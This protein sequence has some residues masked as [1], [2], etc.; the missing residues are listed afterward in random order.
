MNLPRFSW[1][2]LVGMG[3]LCA[4]CSWDWDYYADH[5]ADNSRTCATGVSDAR[6]ARLS[7]GIDL[8]GWLESPTSFTNFI[9]DAALQ[10]FAQAGVTFVRA[11]FYAP[12]LFDTTQPDNLNSTNLS[13]FR[14]AVDRARAAGLGIVFVPYFEPTFKQQLEDQDPSTGAN[15]LDVLLRMWS[16]FASFINEQ[17][18]DWVYPELFG[19]ADFSNSSAWNRILQSLAKTVRNVAPRHT[20]I[21]D[22]NSGKFRVDWN[23]IGALKNLETIADDHNVIYGFI[24]FDPV[25][26]THQGATWRPEWP[27]L[28]YV[29][30]VAYPSSP[31]LVAPAL[32]AITDK[33]AYAEVAIYGDESWGPE[34]LSIDID[35]VAQWSADNCARVM[36]VEFGVYR[37]YAPP[38]SAARWVY[39]VRTL[40]E[41]RR[42]AWSYWSYDSDQFTLLPLQPGPV[43]EP[44]IAT[45]LGL[46]E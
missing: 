12:A 9:S 44:A 2:L 6:V 33:V 45:S 27:E 37:K 21:V 35:Q 34:R 5:H 28:Q 17:D 31:Q 42:I 13:Y 14:Q 23:S 38:D 19:A 40:L 24:Y 20:I 22:G 4:G 11:S 46:T 7:R 36:C 43:I 10:R 8:Y 3:A 15:A 26:F 29:Q 41:Q 16:K 1:P 25:I 30:G 39:D 32:S 18:P